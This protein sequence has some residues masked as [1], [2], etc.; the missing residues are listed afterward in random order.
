MGFLQVVSN[1]LNKMWHVAHE[2]QVSVRGHQINSFVTRTILF[3]HHVVQLLIGGGF[4]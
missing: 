3:S 4:V 2:E 1:S